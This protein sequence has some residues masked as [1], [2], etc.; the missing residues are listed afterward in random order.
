MGTRQLPPRQLSPGGNSPGGNLRPAVTYPTRLL[1]PAVTYPTRQLPPAVT[2][3]TRQLPPVVTYPTRQLFP[4]GN[5]PGSNLPHAV[6]PSFIF[7]TATPPLRQLSRLYFLRDNSD[8]GRF[9]PGGKKFRFARAKIYHYRSFRV[10]F[11]PIEE[12]SLGRSVAGEN[13]LWRSIRR[14][15]V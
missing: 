3:P 4:R 13:V 15:E 10:G 11:C 9:W 12:Y 7:H 6:I 8:S 14:E 5:S 1:P 2:Y